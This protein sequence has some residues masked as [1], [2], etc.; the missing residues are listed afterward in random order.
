GADRLRPLADARGADARYAAVQALRRAFDWPR[1]VVLQDGDGELPVDLD[2]ALAVEAFAGPLGRRDV[3]VIE[4]LFP[5]DGGLAA[6]GPEGGYVHELV[7]PLLAPAPAP[8][9][10]DPP[11][12]GALTSAARRAPGGDWLY[13]KLSC[14]PAAADR[15]LEAA[16][17][18]VVR[19]AL[20][21]GAASAWFFVR[22][23]E[24]HWHLRLRV[25]GDRARLRG[26]VQPALEDACAPLLEEGTVWRLAY[27]T[28]DREVER[29]GGVEGMAAAEDIFHA[30]SE[31]VASLLP[32][33]RGGPDDARWQAALLGLDAL[34]GDLGLGE[35]ERLGL[36]GAMRASFALEFR[37]PGDPLRHG[38]G[39]AYRPRRAAIDGLFA[40]SAGG[41]VAALREAFAARSARVAEPAERLRALARSG[42]LTRPLPAIAAA[43]LH[44]HANRWFA[45]AAREHEAVL[46]DFLERTYAARAARKGRRGP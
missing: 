43:L 46:Y 31:A 6:R 42:R 29:Y 3:A 16:A 9:P 23:D 8:R 40:P 14:G 20:A 21:S 2:N 39:A 36:V 30:D 33:T 11:P 10:L 17:L 34:L 18:P 38:I 4:E 15:V 44:M 13:A 22:Y 35:G 1:F 7:V 28:Y 26:E 5:G 37:A 12:L 45:S 24:P 19:R 41:D 25:R 27:D 32:R